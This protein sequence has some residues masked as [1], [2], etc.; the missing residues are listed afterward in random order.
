MRPP[1]KLLERLAYSM[2]GVANNYMSNV[3]PMLALPIFSIGLGVEAWKVGLALAVPRVWDAITDPII[4][5]LTLPAWQ[6]HVPA[7]P[8]CNPRLR[9]LHVFVIAHSATDKL[10]RVCDYNK[11]VT[12]CGT[13]RFAQGFSEGV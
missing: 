3:L 11:L 8:T 6:T 5:H 2:G 9:F 1:P 12:A 10:H 7:N 4:G 13:L